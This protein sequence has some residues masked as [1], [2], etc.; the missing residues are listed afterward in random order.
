MSN[1]SHAWSNT[2]GDF[3]AWLDDAGELHL[4]GRYE[5]IN[6]KGGLLME[7]FRL[8]EENARLRAVADASMVCVD[9]L[10]KKR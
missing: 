3:S 5:P 9:L 8:L 4:D 1:P 6:S 10:V 2:K 7:I